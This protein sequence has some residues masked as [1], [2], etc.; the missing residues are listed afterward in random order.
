MSLA[1]RPPPLGG[2]SPPLGPGS[3]LWRLPGLGSPR[4][5]LLW[6]RW[7]R[8]GWLGPRSFRSGGAGGCPVGA[9]AARGALLPFGL[10]PGPPG[11][12]PGPLGACCGL[13]RAARVPLCGSLARCCGGGRGVLPC[14][15]PP[16]RPRWGLP[17]ARGLRHPS[18][19]WS[20]AG[21]SGNPAGLRCFRF[22]A[23]CAG[24]AADQGCATQKFQGFWNF[25]LTGA[26]PGAILSMRGPFRSFGGC[27]F[28]RGIHGRQKTARPKG[29]AVFLCPGDLAALLLPGLFRC[30]DFGGVNSEPGPRSAF[31]QP[32]NN[33]EIVNWPPSSH[34]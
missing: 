15:P 1:R 12:T 31:F 6:G 29:R 10:V 2:L 16:C 3:P 24:G 27:P 33:P 34:A 28:P 25:L 30:S 22:A 8:R 5:A 18:G 13:F 14:F 23:L 26:C 32:V 20:V 21:L 4:R 7:A 19:W 11:S 17:G 9:A